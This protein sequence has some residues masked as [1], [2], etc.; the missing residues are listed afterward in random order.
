MKNTMLLILLFFSTQIVNRSEASL[1]KSG[2]NNKLELAGSGSLLVNWLDI[3]LFA[4][5]NSKTPTHHF[6]QSAYSSIALYE[7]LVKG[8][9][10]FTSIAGQLNGLA[11]PATVVPPNICWEA[12]GNAALAAMYRFFYADDPVSVRKIDSMELACKA[13]FI[14]NGYSEEE[15]KTGTEVGKTIAGAIIEWSKTDGADKINA[16]FD[17]PKGMGLWEPTPPMFVP[18]I[19]AF[20]GNCRTIVKGS[21]ENT[22]PPPP[23]AF[24][25]DPQS[26]FYKMVNEVH[27]PSTPLDNEKRTIALFWDDFPDGKSLTAGGHWASI[28]KNEILEKQ[29]SLIEGAQIYSEMFI[30]MNDA[31]IGCFKAKYTYK[32]LRPV[33]YIQKYMKDANWAP[34]IITPSHPEYPAAHATVSTA[35]A[36]VLSKVLG[37]QTP[38]IDHS[39]DYKG[40]N[41]RKF[42]N[43]RAASNEAGISRLYGG[44]HYRPSIEAGYTQGEKVAANVLKTLAYK[45]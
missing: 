1:L 37:S 36:V 12:S 19:N 31:A 15:V 21:I 9:E 23:I 40:M 17:V 39:Y 43:F 28:L 33:T 29:L 32:L 13:K 10:S 25:T 5:K 6:R 3:Q 27:A 2:K 7:A 41:P 35:A 26:P 34:L 18:P 24:S 8:S 20:M 22:I 14:M 11:L 45:K 4:I 16:P 30:A 38:F 44:I 42:A